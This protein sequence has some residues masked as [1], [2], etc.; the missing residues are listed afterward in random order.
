MNLRLPYM[1]THTSVNMHICIYKPH[2]YVHEGKR[3]I[4]QTKPNNN[5]RTRKQLDSG[6]TGKVGKG[7]LIS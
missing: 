2:T 4:N 3:R 1:C 7:S 6:N 5:S